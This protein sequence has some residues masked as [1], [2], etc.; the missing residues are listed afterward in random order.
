VLFT[1]LIGCLAFL[2]VSNN[3][4]TVFTWFSSELRAWNVKLGITLTKCRHQ[5]HLWLHRMDRRHGHIPTF[6]KS[7]ATPQHDG[8]SAAPN[9][10]TALRD[11]LCTIHHHHSDSHQRLPR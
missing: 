9:K 5:Y 11:I 2:N 6:Q 1:W 8:C 4:A 10:A 3:G 7:H